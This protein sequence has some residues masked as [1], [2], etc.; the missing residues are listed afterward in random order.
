MLSGYMQQSVRVLDAESCR[1]APAGN[2]NNSR[3]PGIRGE[4]E[5]MYKEMI[6][7]VARTREICAA[8]GETGETDFRQLKLR[9]KQEIYNNLLET[10]IETEVDGD[11]E[12][13]YLIARVDDDC[14]ITFLSSAEYAEDIDQ[15]LDD[16]DIEIDG[17]DEQGLDDLERYVRSKIESETKRHKLALL[18]TS[19]LTTAGSYD[20]VDIS[21]EEAWQL[22]AGNIYNLDSAV[23]HQSTAEI[24]TT[25]LGVDV[26]VNR[27]MFSQEI[28]QKALVF[29]LNGRPQEGKILTA[30]EIEQI[31]YKFQVLT[32]TS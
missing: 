16:M 24:M 2:K 5:K 14:K 21:L 9:E 32:R 6:N 7:W 30:A 13:C 11:D 28:G 20:L 4:S 26:P 8:S 22:V 12:V 18:N 15:F 1:I 29:K 25:L 10:G 31:G 3:P 27:Q 17:E 23:G 19:I